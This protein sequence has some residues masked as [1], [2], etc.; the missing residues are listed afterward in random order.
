MYRVTK[1]FAR[2]VETTLQKFP[3]R[4]AAE[5]FIKDKLIEDARM[6]VETTYRIYDDLDEMVRAF[7]SADLGKNTVTSY[8]VSGQGRGSSQTF[9]PTPFNVRPQPGGLPHSWVKD[10]ENE[11]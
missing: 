10:V 5:A 9:N 7:T 8:Q 2:G 3:R 11:E 1:Q 4:D 6:K